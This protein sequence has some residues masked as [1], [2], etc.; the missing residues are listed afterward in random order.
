MEAF[1]ELHVKHVVPLLAGCLF[2]YV[3]VRL[4]LN[5]FSPDLSD[6]PGDFLGK[7]TDAWRLWKMYRSEQPVWVRG[8]LKK[9]KTSAVRVGPNAVYVSDPSVIDTVYGVKDDYV[10][11]CGR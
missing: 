1:S 5:Y 8:M 7:C 3:V 11:V 4:A 2:S 9:Y 6:V 10:K